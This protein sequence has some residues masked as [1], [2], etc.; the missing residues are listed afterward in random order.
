MELLGILLSIIALAFYCL[1]LCVYHLAI[2]I[3]FIILI[4]ELIK[5]IFE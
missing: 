1:V 3:A 2:P 4:V 5:S